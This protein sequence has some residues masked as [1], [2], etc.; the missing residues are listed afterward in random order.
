[1]KTAN[2]NARHLSKWDINGTHFMYNKYSVSVSATEY[3][4]YRVIIRVI[5]L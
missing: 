4:D 1:M 5:Y 3:T 2:E